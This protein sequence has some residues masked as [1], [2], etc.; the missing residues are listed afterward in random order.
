[1]QTANEQKD[2]AKSFFLAGYKTEEISKKLNVSKRTLYYWRKLYSWEKLISNICPKETIKKRLILL[3]SMTSKTQKQI[4]EIETL[5]KSLDLF[6]KTKL[7]HQR[8]ISKA[9]TKKNNKKKVKNDLSHL[10]EKEILKPFFEYF[11][12]YQLECWKVRFERTRIY[13]KGRQIGF[14]LYFAIEGFVRGLL[15]GR[16][17]IFLSASKDQS[18]NFRDYIFMICEKFYNVQLQGR[19]KI[20]IKGPNG[21]FMLY[22]L[23]TNQNTAQGY[24]GDL[25]IDE[26]FWIPNFKKL[27]TVASGIATHKHFTKTYFS[28]PNP[29]NAQAFNMWSYND[30]NKKLSS[31]NKPNLEF[32]TTKELKKGVRGAD[33]SFRQLIT[34]YSAIK[35][36]ATFFDLEELKQEYSKDDF[37]MLF[38][39]KLDF[40]LDAVFKKKHL[41]LCEINVNESEYFKKI[42]RLAL[43]KKIDVY[44]GFDPSKSRDISSIAVLAK[45]LGIADK[46]CVLEIVNMKKMSWRKQALQVLELTKKYSVECISVDITGPG[47]AVFELI[48]DDF[49]Q[50]Y[51]LNYSLESKTKLVL[52][53]QDTIE[54]TRILWSNENSNITNAFMK[55]KKFVTKSGNISYN[56][57]RSDKEGH[58]DEAF[59]IMNA[60]QNEELL[61]QD[62]FE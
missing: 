28:T 14:T 25:Y 34:I 4:I 21:T 46:F 37:A 10:S 53:A 19:D 29:G 5:T 38:E 57:S 7:K 40:N 8:E 31:Q 22:F 6:E 58:A 62:Q 26:F 3:S 1:M 55:I 45:P 48:E 32:L 12:S 30:L 2:I 20:Q 39:C 18:D 59:A 17:K 15:D 41:D 49:Y 16:N 9:N 50:T 51:P 23:S 56:A 60:L 24:T 42:N 33:G 52:K 27:Q 44:I 43:A 35:K 54:Q 61:Y 36:G 13:I 11:F 47:G